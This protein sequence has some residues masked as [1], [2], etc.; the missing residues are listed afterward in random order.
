MNGREATQYGAAHAGVL[1]GTDTD[2]HMPLEAACE[3]CGGAVDLSSQITVCIV[4]MDGS[5]AESHMTEANARQLLLEMGVLP[6][7]VM[8]VRH[9]PNSFLPVEFTRD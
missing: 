9:D 7:P 6:P 1:K 4:A 3:E 8:C 5:E 2:F